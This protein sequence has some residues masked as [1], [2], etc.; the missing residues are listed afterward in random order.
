MWR[1]GTYDWSV[2]MEGYRLFKKD[3]LEAQG[4]GV[5]LYVNDQLECMEF[6]LGVDE[7]PTESLWVRQGRDR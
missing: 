4:E 3:S 7:E 5:D 2:G 1:E 6:C